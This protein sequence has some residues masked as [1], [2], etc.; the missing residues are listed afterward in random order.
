MK[1]KIFAFLFTVMVI[2]GTVGINSSNCHFGINS[3]IQAGAASTTSDEFLQSATDLSGTTVYTGLSDSSNFNM[4]GRTYYQGLVFD[5][6]YYSSSNTSSVTFNVSDI[7]EF[8]C[9]IGHVDNSSRDSATVKV[10]LDD[11]L[12]DEF[13]L[14]SNMP[15]QLYDLDVSDSA[16]LE[17]VVKRNSKSIYA[18]AN[19]T[20]D[21]SDITK[22]YDV[23][24]YSSAE[25]FIASGYGVVGTTVYNGKSQAT[26]FNMN[27]RTYYQGLAFDDTYYSSSNTSRIYYNTENV[28]SFSCTIG[29]I[30]NS[31]RDS[32]TVKVY[33]DDVLYEEFSLTSNMPLMDYSLDISDANNLLFVVSRNSQSKY[34]FADI[35]VDGNDTIRPC[36]IPTYTSA[37]DFI[38]NGYGVVGTTVYN[39]KSQATTFNMNGRTYYQ[40]LAFD[41]T[42][43]SSSN[44]SRIYYN[45]ENVS[46]FSCT[47]GH[48]D[49]S[50]RDSA[51]VKVYL[52]DVLYEEFSLT[53][54]MP[55]M[56]YSLDISDANNL[57]FVVSRNSQSKYAFA[58]ISVD[59]NDTIRPCSI[60]IYTSAEDFITNGYGREGMTIY[61]GK[62]QATTF[63]INGDTYN[64]GIAFD[65]IY[66]SSS[67]SS[68]IYYNTEN[69]SEISF[70]IGHIDGSAEK[71]AEFYIY[72]DDVL[73][74]TITLTSAMSP[75]EYCLNT[76][77]ANN[78]KFICDRTGKSQYAM[79]D[80]QIV[81]QEKEYIAGDVNMDGK[82]SISDV[83]LL[84]KWVLA[85]PNTKL[86]DWK[87]ADFCEDGRLDVL[88]LSLMKKALLNQF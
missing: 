81:T 46:S 39:G 69:L 36:S 32:A 15:L 80:V 58:D 77:N 40:G 44:T 11:I 51:T 30:D 35:S 18:F 4:N 79:A 74:D 62:S 26:T 55:L 8:A 43:Y 85:V 70:L 28:S 63:S 88:D 24:E 83:V 7:S 23:P 45:T 60:P 73:Y 19:I 16:T 3:S 54:N 65:N 42:Y 78:V 82:F 34:A 48:I 72:L 68:R 49:N 33:L 25:E 66:Y 5:D 2:I 84:Q 20:V 9:T 59:G 13:D 64:Q 53:S 47:I 38:T 76:E 56:D 10:Y 86:A 37:E 1:K 31:S 67:N 87:A 29:H 75:L 21:G 27:G 41:D 12:Q 17:F 52:D 22:S 50:S 14:T 57:L 6:T 71:D 61:N